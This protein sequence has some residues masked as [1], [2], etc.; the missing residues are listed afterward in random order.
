MQRLKIRLRASKPFAVE[1]PRYRPFRMGL[2]IYIV[3]YMIYFV[4]LYSILTRIK[5]VPGVSPKIRSIIETVIMLVRSN[6]YIDIR[7]TTMRCSPI[8]Y[9]MFCVFR[10]AFHITK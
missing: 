10:L 5:E 8:M 7:I 9:D 4:C 6:V 3:N 2:A 1:D